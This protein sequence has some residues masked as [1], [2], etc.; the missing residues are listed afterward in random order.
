MKREEL[1]SELGTNNLVTDLRLSFSRVSAFDQDGP[2]T[3]IHKR[4]VDNDGATMG[5]IVDTLAFEPAEFD[6]RYYVFNH[7]KPTA[8]A[9]DLADVIIKEYTHIPNVE[10]VLSIVKANGFWSSTKKEETLIAKF[11]TPEFWGYVKAMLEVGERKL[12]TEEE[13]ESSQE[14]VTTLKSHPHSKEVMSYPLEN[15]DKYAQVELEFTYKQFA[16]LGIVDL[17]IVNHKDK[18]VKF[19]DLKT[20]AKPALQFSNSFI[21][22]RYYLQAALYTIGA[23]TFM[24]KYNIA[25]YT[26]LPFEFLYISRFERVPLLYKVTE[27]WHNAALQGFT[28]TSGYRYKGLNEL[29][30]DIDWHWTNK[31]YSLS[32]EVYQQKGIVQLNDDFITVNE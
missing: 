25:D 27:K 20:G 3:L 9:G 5:G 4:Q 30:D 1:L 24:E 13:K 22:F 8:T 31:V 11:D 7:S 2:L 10:E 12:I 17:V 18:T 21:K 6:K 19:V 15:E 23:K 28:T 32:R 14:I 16:F 26:L 29:L